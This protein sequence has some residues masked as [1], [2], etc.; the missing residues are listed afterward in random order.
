MQDATVDRGGGGAGPPRSEDKVVADTCPHVFV[1][2]ALPQR[3]IYTQIMAF[4][5]PFSQGHF[6]D[7]LSGQEAG[8][9]IL[10]DVENVTDRVMRILGGNP[11]PMQLQGTNTYL[12][13]TGP[14]R[15][16]IDTGEV[17]RAVC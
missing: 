5:I 9:P 1:Q 11:G 17:S 4:R 16:L 3:Y 10:E 15:I 8:L 13:G 6:S 2:G 7:Y 14:S 12:V